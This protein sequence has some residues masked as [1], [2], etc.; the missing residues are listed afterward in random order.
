MASTKA[1]TSA[2]KHE[3][4]KVDEAILKMCD[5]LRTE[6]LKTTG[7][8]IDFERLDVIHLY[9]F[10]FRANFRLKPNGALPRLSD[11]HFVRCSPGGE[12]I[13]AIPEFVVYAPAN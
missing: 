11:S 10:N 9:N 2:E 4:P 3:T 13:S 5:T 7:K 12:I 6:I 1:T 8:P